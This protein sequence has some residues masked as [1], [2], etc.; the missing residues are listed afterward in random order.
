MKC[1]STINRLKP[2]QKCT[3]NGYIECKYGVKKSVKLAV[4]KSWGKKKVGV[5]LGVKK[6]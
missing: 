4:K 3:K 6:V 2:T 1:N 5:K